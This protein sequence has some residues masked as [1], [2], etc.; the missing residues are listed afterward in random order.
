M[1]TFKDMLVKLST[2]SYRIYKKKKENRIFFKRKL[3]TSRRG[4]ADQEDEGGQSM[5][6]SSS[7]CRRAIFGSL[8]TA[9]EEPGPP[10]T[11]V[12][13]LATII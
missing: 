11:C 9:L 12:Y 10:T 7:S 6:Y 1:E 3:F 5:F 8:F 13:T 4:K 2:C